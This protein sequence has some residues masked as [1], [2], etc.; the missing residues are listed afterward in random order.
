MPFLFKLYFAMMLH[1]FGAVPAQIK[2]GNHCPHFINSPLEIPISLAGNFG[3]IR[4]NH[5][6]TGWDVKTENKEG[7]P[8]KAAAAGFVS[9]I[10]VS[11]TGYGLAIYITHP[12]GFTTVYAHLNCLEKRFA[13]LLITEQY[14]QKK[15]E[16]DIKFP[17]RKLNVKSG[18]TIAQSGNSG[19]STAPHLHFEVRDAF[20]EQAI[21][22]AF[23]GLKCEDKIEPNIVALGIYSWNNTFAQHH[24]FSKKNFIFKND[25]LQFSDK[26]IVHDSIIAFAINAFDHNN[27]SENDLGVFKN[28]LFV[29]EK[30][31]QQ[32]IFDRLI[33]AQQMMINGMIDFEQ[34]RLAKTDWLRLFKLQGVQHSTFKTK[35]NGWI[36]LKENETKNVVIN[37]SDENGNKQTLCFEVVYEPALSRFSDAFKL[38]KWDENFYQQFPTNTFFS[39][40]AFR[41]LEKISSKNQTTEMIIDTKNNPPKNKFL[42]K[43]I[44]PK[45]LENKQKTFVVSESKAF[46]KTYHKPM[47]QGDTAVAWVKEFG[48][49]YLETDENLPTIIWKNEQQNFEHGDK[50]FFEI[51]DNQTGIENFELLSNNQWQLI[52]LDAK[53]NLLTA[54]LDEHW[55]SG[56][57][58]VQLIVSDKGGNRATKTF[59]VQIK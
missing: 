56:K 22:P 28:E 32:I 39:D 24:F 57:Q 49:F 7:L 58:N 21:N 37:V 47:W 15:F 20:T 5:F 25:T 50:L 42:V 27:E 40:V 51:K 11:P 18:E 30:M 54:N 53:N 1:Q 55:Q 48:K 31:Q 4:E 17:V 19:G 3:E 12:Q 14:R 9:R 23:F 52:S 33:F 16:V 38:L 2:Y 45:N 59:S 36:K 35:N 44:A 43:L 10:K 34:Q 13:D 6:H 29:D 26:I 46:G 8:V 41:I